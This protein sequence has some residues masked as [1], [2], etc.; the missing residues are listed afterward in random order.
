M[1]NE[2]MSMGLRETAGDMECCGD[3]GFYD[4]QLQPDI[5]AFGRCS[6]IKADLLILFF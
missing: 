5:P 4:S 2:D 3:L 6:G 1:P